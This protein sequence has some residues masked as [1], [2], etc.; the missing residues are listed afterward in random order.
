MTNPKVGWLKPCPICSGLLFVEGSRGGFFCCE[1]QT[2][3]EGA[4]PARIVESR[5]TQFCATTPPQPEPPSCFEC[6]HYDGMGTSWPGMCRYFETIGQEAKEINFKTVDPMLGCKC[7]L[8]K[9]TT[10]HYRAELAA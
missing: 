2:L 7:Y 3:P 9:P 10:A 1:C 6:S 5:R 8:A 4:K